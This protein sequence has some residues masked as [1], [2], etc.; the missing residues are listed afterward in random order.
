M[1]SK[2]RIIQLLI[3]VFILSLS[4]GCGIAHY[5]YFRLN[6]T[7]NLT[8][9]GFSFD[10][11]S[12]GFGLN[13]DL[14]RKENKQDSTFNTWFSIDPYNYACDKKEKYIFDNLKVENLSLSY[15][16]NVWNFSIH[17]I[18]RF[19]ICRYYYYYDSIVIPSN[20]DSLFLNVSI[21]YLDNNQRIY[22]D[23]S[24]LL[25]RHEG[26]SFYVD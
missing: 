16:N 1:I 11:F 7:G 22:R 21:S 12:C 26:K 2:S 19:E 18:E 24:V 4:S 14:G 3:V 8:I 17:E 5:N 25:Y 15:N 20:L 13:A 9:N 6:K 23:T 10:K